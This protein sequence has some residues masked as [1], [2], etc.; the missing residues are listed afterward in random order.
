M[1]LRALRYTLLLTAIFGITF[2]LR[3]ALSTVSTGTWVAVGNMA[4]A[5]SGA[6]TAVLSDGWLLIS[7]GA[8]ANGPT[9]TADRF[10]TTG[11]WSAAGSMNSR[12]SYH[13]CAL[14]PD[15]R[16]LVAGGTSL[17]GGITNS[18]EIYDPSA[19]SWTQAGNMNDARS[20][21]TTSVLQDGRVLIA[22]GQSSGGALNTLEIFDPA[23]GTFSNAGTMSSPRQDHAAAVLQDGRVLIAGGSSDGAH[24]LSTTEIYD[25]QAGNTFA[26]PAMSTPRARHTA[27][28][29]LGGTVVVIGGSDYSND[30]ASA[31]VFDPAANTFSAASNLATARS[32]HSAFLL[33]NNNEVLV[34]GGQ[35]AGSDLAS[36]ELYIPWQNAFQATGAM[37]A[38]RS[39]ATGAALTSVDGR[40]LIAGG[41]GTS[42]ELY[43]FATVKTDASDYPPGT[44]VH[45]TGS[46]WQPN[47]TVTLTL[48]ESPLIDTHGPYTITADQSGNITDSSFTTDSHDLSVRFWLSAVA[49]TGYKS[50]S[51]CTGTI[52]NGPTIVDVT[53]AN[54]NLGVGNPTSL[55]LQAASL[56]DQGGAFVKWTFGSTTQTTPAICVASPSGTYTATYSTT[57]TA[58]TVTSVSPT[59]GDLNTTENVTITGTKFVAQSTVSFGSNITVNTTTVNSSTQIVANITIGSSAATGVRNV[60]VTNPGSGGGSATGTLVNRFTVNK[61]TSSTSISC[62]PTSVNVNSATTC[63]ASVTDNDTGIVVTPTGNVNFTSSQSGTFSSSGSCALSGSGATATCSVSYTPTTFGGGTHVITGS[64]GGDATHLSIGGAFNLGV[65]NPGTTTTVSSSSNPSTYG[66]SPTF[67][68]KV[69]PAT[70]STVPTGT[71]QF[72]IDGVSVGSQVAVSGCN[73]SPDACATFTPTAAQLPAG[74]SPHSITAVYTGDGTFTGSTSVAFSQTVNAATLTYTANPASR[75]YGVNNPAFTGTVT[76]FA[77]GDTQA[78]AT[79]GTLSFTSPATSSSN[80]GS[81]AI[82]GS[83]LT[84]NNGNYTFMQAASNS[85]ALT[86]TAATLTYTANPASRAYGVNNPGF[87]GTV[88]GFAPGDTQASATTGTLS[89]TSPATSSSNVGSY[90]INGSG[91]TANNGNYTFVQAAGN[92]TALT[93]TAATLT[94]TANPVSRAYGV[95]NPAFSGSV[96]G[97]APGDTQASATTGTLSFT[98]PA[99]SSSNVGSYAINGS[100][101]T[102]NNGNY[103]FVQAASNAT[104]L[105]IS[106][107]TPTVTFT[108]AP[109]NAYF[110]SQFM[111]SATTNASTIAT[112]TAS[113]SCTITG[114][115]V[116]ITA[117]LGTCNLQ[118]NWPADTNYIAASAMQSTNALQIL[119][120]VSV[121]TTTTVVYDGTP[122]AVTPTVTPV[123]AYAETYTGIL[124]TEYTTSSSAPTEPGSYTVVATV[125]DANYTGSGMGTLTIT[126]KDPA[127][128]LALRS[129]MPEPSYYGYRVYYELTT[130]NSPCPTGQVQFFV[131]GTASTTANL[132]KSPCTTQ[133]IEFSTA[134]LTPGMHTVYAVYSGDTYY[135]PQTSASVSHQVDA[136][137][138]SVL[139]ATSAMMVYVGDPVTLTATVTL[140]H[141]ID[142]SAMPPSGTVQFFDNTTTLLGESALSSN[143]AMFAIDSLAAGSHSL[144]ATYVSTNGDFAG[145]SSPVSVETVDKISPSITWPS[146]ADIVYGTKLGDT[147][148]NATAT[149]AHHS[150]NPI[151][152]TFT[153]NPAADTVLAVGPFN[154]RSRSSTADS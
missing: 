26:G 85:T 15:G 91:L 139:L 27:T 103:T 35:A 152:G 49:W 113:G 150:G 92:A 57:A 121:P 120:T 52:Q 51:D 89:F 70:G 16:V 32:K 137:G 6:C 100:G 117:G 76:G 123:V 36:A 88:T 106:Q 124:P 116:T 127:L 138:T 23:S 41:S 17:G 12:R 115:T 24:A 110:N 80:V 33:P 39:D 53:S 14:L 144:T 87:T 59:S 151:T 40:L 114:T 125:T 37:A 102:A 112:I 77:P 131:D 133:P 47:E 108:G 104:A 13:S 93:V 94:Y 22:G 42:A 83:G 99:T 54:Q 11:S 73:P 38:A 68:A 18:A 19:N 97:F 148:L 74:G 5:R 82:N 119:V 153:Y 64:Y 65:Q 141:P 81:Y 20:G 111:V 56:S 7:G 62:L 135:L 58:P 96:T 109:A 60:S 75:A 126:Q 46:G 8:D 2:L 48:V 79:S 4:A 44:T 143:T 3:A 61:R 29:L 43:G 149:D 10:G 72:Q 105:T 107:A 67:T 9:A 66:S 142:G 145:S 31:E 128:A 147:Q 146:P 136:D 130:V 45:I 140:A 50:S 84:A 28:T 118:A 134:T 132:S 21:A 1:K 63:S 25:P 129:G 34:V 86:V 154:L 30:L 122:K 69:A 71:V 101:L 95:N 78:S 55:E 90:A 98:S